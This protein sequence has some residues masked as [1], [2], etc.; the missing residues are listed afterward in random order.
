MAEELEKTATDMQQLA[1]LSKHAEVGPSG[2]KIQEILSQL[3]SANSWEK[4]KIELDDAVSADTYDYTKIMA[5]LDVCKGQNLESSD[6]DS[7]TEFM[8]KVYA[9]V[10]RTAHTKDISSVEEIAMFN[11]AIQA[12][13]AAQELVEACVESYAHVFF[14]L[15]ISPCHVAQDTPVGEKQ[16]RR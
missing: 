7:V 6:Q 2:D 11:T 12:L 16:R 4:L 13:D 10:A 3:C 8:T 5:R 14:K 9:S 15:T 1:R